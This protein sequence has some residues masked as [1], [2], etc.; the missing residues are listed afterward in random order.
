[1]LTTKEIL[2]FSLIMVMLL[3]KSLVT[4]Y[5]CKIL[6][7]YDI[8]IS[9]VISLIIV[10]ILML[11][12]IQGKVCSAQDTFHFET[13]PS[14]LCD[15]GLYMAQAGPRHEFCTKLL[16]TPE[17]QKEVNKYSC[18]GGGFNGRPVHFIRDTLSND[19]W[20]NTMCN[21]G[22]ESDLGVPPVL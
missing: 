16:S 22:V 1:M 4:N 9:V 19:K 12:Y 14:K 20:E 7:G 3:I 11:V 8:I 17:G 15:G 6:G 13:T 21:G 5:L 10:L 2:F 18:T